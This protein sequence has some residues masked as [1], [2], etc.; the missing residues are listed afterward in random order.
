MEKNTNNVE[1]EAARRRINEIDDR[2]LELLSERMD[3]SRRLGAAKKILKL[4]L[5]DPAREAAILARL[6]GRNADGV[7]PA[8][9]NGIWREILSASR[10][11]QAPER[12]AYLGPEGTFTQQAALTRFGSSAEM[13]ACQSIAAVFALIQ[14]R[15]VDHAVLPVE[16][17]LQGIV[18]ET[19]DL[20]GSAGQPLITGEITLPIHFVFSSGLAD[21]SRVE[22]V[23]S[24][25]EAFLQCS[26]FLGQPAL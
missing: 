10:R 1:F 19:V 8:A 23:Y 11:I 16:N 13:I 21:L 9:I 14:N 24:K 22:R 6:A 25:R 12:V 20:L 4:P 3:L 2:L 5:Y 26:V 18:G 17:T 7:A 15:T